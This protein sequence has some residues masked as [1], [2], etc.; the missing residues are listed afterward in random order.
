VELPRIALALYYEVDAGDFLR[1][2]FN[3]TLGLTLLLAVFLM[4]ALP[5]PLALSVQ[6]LTMRALGKVRPFAFE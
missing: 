4:V 6:A 2:L 3:P 5:I 1:W